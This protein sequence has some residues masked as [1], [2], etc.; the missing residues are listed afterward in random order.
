M[1]DALLICNTRSIGWDWHSCYWLCDTH[2]AL[3]LQ[4]FIAEAIVTAEPKTTSVQSPKET[5]SAEAS[6]AFQALT[7]IFAN[8]KGPGP[9][10]RYVLERI[11]GELVFRQTEIDAALEA[12]I[13]ALPDSGRIASYRRI[14]KLP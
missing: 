12:A 14:I 8:V 4:S 10:R 7:E 3:S 9:Y 11:D 1:P 2:N 6:A 13:A 5:P